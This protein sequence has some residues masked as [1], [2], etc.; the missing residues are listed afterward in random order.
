MN[1]IQQRQRGLED[2][3]VA[4]TRYRRMCLWLLVG[5]TASLVAFISCGVMIRLGA[6]A[7]SGV[8]FLGGPALA[9]IAVFGVCFGV[10][11][12]DAHGWGYGN[13]SKHPADKVRLAQR[14]YDDALTA[15]AEKVIK[16]DRT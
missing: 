14:A 9:G 6:A 10:V 1:D 11:V 16:E 5:F 8:W 7:D 4:L 3:Q 13:R 15:Q 2:A 12:S